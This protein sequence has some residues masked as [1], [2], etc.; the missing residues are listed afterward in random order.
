MTTIPDVD[1]K[2]GKALQLL[3][4]R[5]GWDLARMAVKI[6][7]SKSNV[8][9]IEQ[10]TLSP[11]HEKLV[12]FAKAFGCRPSSIVLLAEALEG[13]KPGVTPEIGELIKEILQEPETC[14]RIGKEFRHN[15]RVAPW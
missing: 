10:G 1:T 3:R 7:F 14:D 6:G 2:I 11:T 13:K 8:G 4:Q 9:A 15:R 12:L 5:K